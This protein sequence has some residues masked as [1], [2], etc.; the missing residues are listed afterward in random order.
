[1]Q[2]PAR[3]AGWE[4]AGE[5][6]TLLETVRASGASVLLGLSGS[7]GAFDASIARAMAANVAR[8]M[9]FPLSNPT[10]SAE[11]LPEDLYRWTEGR[12]IVATGS[13]FEP[14]LFEGVE[15]PVGQGNNAF[16]FPGLGFGAI[17]TEAR[18]ITDGLVLEAAYALTDYTAERYLEQGL[19]Y[20]PIADLREASVRVTARVLRRAVEEGVAG[21][22]GLPE[23]LEQ[24]ES[25]VRE[26]FWHPRYL[27]V[28]R[29]YI[30]PIRKPESD[31]PQGQGAKKPVWDGG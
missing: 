28:V 23:T 15:H 31:L 21:R 18:K 20:P 4:C 13:P 22:E 30:P 12:A 19:I 27:P 8:P 5:I 7:A 26:R 16:I 17:L 2:S 11:A 3:I 9:I 25:F 1:A 24:A 6:P 10:D 29:G 14:V